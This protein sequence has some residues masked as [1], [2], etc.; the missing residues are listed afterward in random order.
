MTRNLNTIITEIPAGSLLG[1]GV[2]QGTI[3]VARYARDL[4]QGKE[5]VLGSIGTGIVSYG[6]PIAM[7]T[8]CS[9][10]TYRALKGY[11]DYLVRNQK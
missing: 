2:L 8:I 10:I 4:V 5:E 1:A 6:I 3:N 11:D 9:R 7:F